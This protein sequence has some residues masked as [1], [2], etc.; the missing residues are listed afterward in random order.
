MSVHDVAADQLRCVRVLSVIL[1]DGSLPTPGTWSI[2][3]FTGYEPPIAPGLEGLF[4]DALNPPAAA[5]LRALVAGYAE[6]FGLTI[7]EKPHGGKGLVGVHATGR[8][9]GID[10]HIWGPARADVDSS[11]QCAGVAS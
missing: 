7:E 3:T 8:W 4:L 1:A 11:A 2:H 5:D 9:Q 10:L 6:K